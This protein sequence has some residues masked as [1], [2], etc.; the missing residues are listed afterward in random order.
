MTT[1]PELTMGPLALWRLRGVDQHEL[2]CEVRCESNCLGL[3]VYDSS[4][5]WKLISEPHADLESLISRSRRMLTTCLAEGWREPHSEEARV[6][7][8]RQR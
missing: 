7:S 2:V 5:G 3:T 1:L 6:G 8:S 4:T